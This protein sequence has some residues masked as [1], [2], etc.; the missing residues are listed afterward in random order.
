MLIQPLMILERIGELIKLMADI[1]QS[2]YSAYELYTILEQLALV[3]RSGLTI[4]EGLNLLEDDQSNPVFTRLNDSFKKDYNLAKSFQRLNF[5]SVVVS[6]LTLAQETGKYDRL[7]SYLAQYYKAQFQQR[8]QLKELVQMPLMI[9]TLFILLLNGI[10]FY[11]LPL[12]KSMITLLNQADLVLLVIF[13]RFIQVLSLSFL[14]LLMCMGIL[15]IFVTIKRLTNSNQPD[16]YDSF[17]FLQKKQAYKLDTVNLI[18]MANILYSSGISSRQSL[19]FCLEHLPKR[20]LYQR[21]YETTQG[22]KS[23]QGLIEALIE[24]KIFTALET[25]VLKLSFHTGQIEQQLQNLVITKQS[26][27][28]QSFNH[29]LIRLEPILLSILIFLVLLILISVLLPLFQAIE[30]LT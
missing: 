19:D 4:E 22:L 24:S 30:V 28:D 20:E 10:G 21:L 23:N 1:K 12:L 27:S 25:R 13:E 26:E 3:M 17:L 15:A 11:L 9:M 18:L 6:I 5:P 29:L 8:Q 7:F 14:G 16:V 2:T